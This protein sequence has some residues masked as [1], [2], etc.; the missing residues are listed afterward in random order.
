MLVPFAQTQSPPIEDFLATVLYIECRIENRQFNILAKYI[1]H[2]AVQV[3]Y[4]IC[5]RVLL[6]LGG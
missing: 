2:R 6:F 1:S 4:L 5:T 3:L